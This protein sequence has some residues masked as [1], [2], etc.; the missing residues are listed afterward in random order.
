MVDLN[1]VT[2]PSSLFVNFMLTLLEL[3]MDKTYR[4]FCAEV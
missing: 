1:K 2:L 3:A 4:G